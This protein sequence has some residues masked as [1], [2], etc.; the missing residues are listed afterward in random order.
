VSRFGEI[1]PAPAGGWSVCAHLVAPGS[2]GLFSKAII[3]SGACDSKP[4]AQA[5]AEG[6]EFAH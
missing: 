1:L 5:E 3:Q 2:R 4:V 6:I